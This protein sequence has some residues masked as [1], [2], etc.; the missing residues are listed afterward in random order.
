MK[1]VGILS[2]AARTCFERFLVPTIF[3]AALADYGIYCVLMEPKMNELIGAIGYFL[4]V[5]FVLSLSLTLWSEEHQWTV[6]DT[7]VHAVAYLV[8]IVDAC[9]LYHIEFGIGG[10][11]YEIFLMHASAIFALLLTVFFLSFNREHDDIPSWNFTLRLIVSLVVCAIIGQILW[12]GLSLLLS[13]MNWLFKVELG[14]K[15]YAV[16]GILFA[17]LLPGLLFLGLIPGGEKKHNHEP[18]RSGFLAGVFRYLFLPLETLYIVVLFIYAIQIFFCWELPN[19]QVSW[20]VIASMVGLIAIE[21]GL[22][23][24]RHADNRS[25][26]H[27]VA[28][29]LPLILTP[30]LLLM[31]VGIVRRFSDYG[32]TI[33]RLYLATLNGWFYIV[34]LGLV[35]FRARRIHWIPI[36]FAA[37]F[38]ITSALPINYTNL[39]RRQLLR[40][41]KS[42]LTQ[43][44]AVLPL[45]AEHYAVLMKSQDADFASRVSSKLKYLEQTFNSATIE[46][47]VT[48]KGHPI[49]FNNY[50]QRDN[51]PTVDNL[52]CSGYANPQQIHIPEGFTNLYFDV[53][54]RDIAIDLMSDTLEVPVSNQKVSDTLIVNLQTLKGYSKRMDDL[55]PI[56]TKSGRNLF[57]LNHFYIHLGI[58][59]DDTDPHDQSP[60]LNLSG[61]LLTKEPQVYEK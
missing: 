9:Y 52:S 54:C 7:V 2:Q 22:Y 19:G 48:Q 12:G 61:Y 6:R 46:P 4:S 31:T 18:L 13:S 38:L 41:V 56:P 11:G 39:A 37:L 26:D 25:F 34:C 16:A 49:Y 57:L 40:E 47:L 10:N 14:W 30:L 1:L 15:W 45:D 17:G 21:F 8:L 29:W 27:V 50:I 42:A 3:A 5:G 43:T 60:Y 35:L 24:T 33:A 28:R 51:E 20:L 36:S 23:P 58:L 32:I 53:R 59:F 55:V 44:K